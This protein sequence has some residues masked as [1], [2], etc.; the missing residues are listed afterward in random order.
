MTVT[1]E[2]IKELRARTGV[3]VV[4]AKQALTNAKGNMDGAITWLREKGKATMA[5]KASRATGEGYIGSY[6]H[7][8]GK[9]A[10]F[11]ALRCET[12]FV[13]R[14]EKFRDLARDLAMHVAAM[15][16]LVV[17]PGDVPEKDVAAEKALAEKQLAGDTK[18]PEIQAK[19]IEGK[20]R[21]FRE[22]R[23]LLTQSFVKDPSQ[24]IEEL[25]RSSIQEIGENITIESFTRVQI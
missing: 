7:S 21:K 3:G 19:I 23:S 15:D 6:L 16:P 14:N 17:S 20:M 12:D 1:M 9:V 11:V 25:I 13:A 4:D 8:N 5:K 24:T 22:E 2:Q 10:A 18:P